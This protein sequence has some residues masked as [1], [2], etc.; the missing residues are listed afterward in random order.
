MAKGYRPVDRGQQFLL[1]PDMT[2]WLPEGHLAW[3][4]IDM[5]A[6]LD[7]AGFHQRA[8]LRRDGRERRNAAGRASY[9]PDMLLTLLMY[10]Y[11]CGQRSS[12]MIERLCETD[13]GFRVICAGD[14]PDHTVISRFR[15]MHLA[16]FEELFAAVLRLCRA[17]GLARLGTV[18][19]DG[20]KLAANASMQANRSGEWLAEQVT[21]MDTEAAEAA[22][23]AGAAEQAAQ[24][25]DRQILAEAERLDAAEDAEF[26]PEDRGDELPP[27]WYGRAGRRARIRAAQAKIEALEA[28]RRAEQDQA[29]AQRAEGDA[30]ALAEAEQALATELATR[31]AA[32]DAWERQWER[33]AADPSVPLPRGRAP[34]PAEQSVQVRRA[35]ERVERARQRVDHPDTAPRPGGRRRRSQPAPTSPEAARRGRRGR[36][37]P[38]K[39]QANITDPDSSVM[40]V[41]NGGWD[42]AYN[43]QVAASADHIIV[44]VDV[45]TNPADITSY[46]TMTA[47]TEQA[48]A[49]LDATD[50]LGTLL[51][52]TGYC[53][54]ETCTRD[55]DAP[56][57]DRLIATG[58]SRSIRQ[59]ARDNPADGPPPAD[60][61]PRDAM[62]HRLR[63]PEGAKLYTRR[64]ATVE[65]TIG[66]LQKILDTLSCRGLAAALGE[67]HLA[68]AVFNLLRIHRTGLT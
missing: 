27:G 68:A 55:P 16:A 48:A 51:F 39:P 10:A 31:E 11:A 35:R 2:E 1:P 58:K 29:A 22:G 15:Q 42:Q 8:A 17:A 38:D 64:G 9:D 12:R 50:E 36:R 54:D 19:I 3:F 46:T 65:P 67:T 59:A 63:T 37:D 47:K 41:K 20:F 13:V 32:Q 56:G 23:A 5:V 40:P 61:S 18:A 25:A 60:A 43:A 49:D 45:T 66:N 57:P 62:D 14:A 30:A 6:E 4:V 7:T 53:S 24:R 21:K 26:G 28:Q 34:V 44:A 52:D 33:A